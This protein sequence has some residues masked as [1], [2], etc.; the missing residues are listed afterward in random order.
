MVPFLISLLLFLSIT[1]GGCF[2]WNKIAPLYD[3]YRSDTISHTLSSLDEQFLFW[4]PRQ[5]DLLHLISTAGGLILGG[6][7]F[8]GIDWRWFIL[9]LFI[10]GF[11]GYQIPH[12]IISLLS[13][14]RM[15]E[16][17]RQI[18]DFLKMMSGALRAGLSLPEAVNQAVKE[19]P[20]PLSQ[21]LGLVLKKLRMGESFEESFKF[22]ERR[23]KV[24]EMSLVVSAIILSNE[25]GGSLTPLF[26]RLENTLA[27]R[28]RI[29]AKI[30]A[31]TAQGKIQGW[32]VGALPLFLGFILFLIDPGLMT[33]FWTTLPGGIGLGLIL[34]LEAA[35]FLL[36]KKIVEGGEV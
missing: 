12:R 2:A 7:F 8:S 15:E 18:P 26:D 11:L 27:E 33:P 28:K 1:A 14:K 34:I 9:A 17:E 5:A 6:L 19:L 29:K 10:S 23:V 22:L 35:G 20:P 30:A 21:E 31:L 3:R 24:D 4:T 13:S 25:A 32:V 16:I 36:I